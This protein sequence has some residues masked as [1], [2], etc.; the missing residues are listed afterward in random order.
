MLEIPAAVQ[1]FAFPILVMVG[2]LLGKYRRY[3]DAP[4][5]VRR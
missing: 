2:R 4:Q 1:R 5:P 3:A